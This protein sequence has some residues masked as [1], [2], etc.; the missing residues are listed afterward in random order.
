MTKEKFQISNKYL[1][2]LS[3][4]GLMA[5]NMLYVTSDNRD[6]NTQRAPIIMY[7]ILKKTSVI[8]KKIAFKLSQWVVIV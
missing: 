7:F 6:Y 4:K 8:K 3:I 1:N 5:V 2:K